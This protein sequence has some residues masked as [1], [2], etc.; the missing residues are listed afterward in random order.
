MQSMG[1]TPFAPVSRP[2]LSPEAARILESALTPEIEV[3][4]NQFLDQ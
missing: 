2:I 1:A 3:K 4:L